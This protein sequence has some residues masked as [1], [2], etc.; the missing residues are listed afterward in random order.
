MLMDFFFILFSWFLSHLSLTGGAPQHPSL[1][2]SP[3]PAPYPH[4]QDRVSMDPSTELGAELLPRLPGDAS[5]VPYV[6][7]RHSASKADPVVVPSDLL[8]LRPS[9]KWMILPPTQL[10]RFS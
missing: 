6:R 2:L 1:F 3:H 7:A 5:W 8:L 4:H 9:P 10:S